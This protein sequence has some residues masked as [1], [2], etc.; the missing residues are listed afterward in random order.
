MFNISP[1]VLEHHSRGIIRLQ[2]FEVLTAFIPGQQPWFWRLHFFAAWRLLFFDDI[3]RYFFSDSSFPFFHDFNCMVGITKQVNHPFQWPTLCALPPANQKLPYLLL[4]LGCNIRW[5]ILPLDATIAIRHSLLLAPWPTSPG[6]YF[7]KSTQI[8]H[9]ATW[10]TGTAFFEPRT[11]GSRV[12]S[13]PAGTVC[14]ADGSWTK[15]SE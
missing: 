14:R 12:E 5:R 9:E 4:V 10:K 15:T 2:F 8:Y 13:L 7:N 3:S 11:V 6:R 1:Q